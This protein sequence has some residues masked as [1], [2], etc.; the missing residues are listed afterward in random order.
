MYVVTSPLRLFRPPQPRRPWHRLFPAPRFDRLAIGLAVWVLVGLL[1]GV[2]SYYKRVGTRY[3]MTWGQAVAAGLLLWAGWMLVGLVVFAAARRYPLAGPRWP[4]RAA[5]YLVAGCF[6]VVAKLLLDWPIVIAFFCPGREQLSLAEYLVGLVP[7][8][9]FRYYLIYWGLV[10]IGHALNSFRQLG[11]REQKAVHLEGRLASAQL[12]MLRLQLHPHFLLNT[13]NAISALIHKDV[14][15]ADRMVAQL[16]DLLRLLLDRFGAAE[17]TLEEELEFLNR[18]LEIEQEHYGARLR[19]REQVEAGLL[20]TWVPPLILQPL[21]EN[22]LKH[23]IRPTKAAGRIT[24]RA[25]RDRHQRR[26]RLEVEDNGVGLAPDYRRGVGLTNMYARLRQ[27]Y[28][29]AFRFELRPAPSGGTLAV[30]ELPFRTKMHAADEA[31]PAS[32]E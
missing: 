25:R 19:V 2:E 15:V 18:Y 12:Q 27:L 13:L 9:G 29:G 17:V 30:L 4:R 20:R 32:A 23:G 10:G 8:Y 11:D 22:A 3:E 26:L 1:D 28:P 16:G 31:Q 7:S 24:V 5:A 14:E 6:C 21:V